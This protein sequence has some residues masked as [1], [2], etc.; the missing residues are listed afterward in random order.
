MDTFGVNYFSSDQPYLIAREKALQW[1]VHE[2]LFQLKPD[3]HNMLQRYILAVFYYQT[4]QK[5]SW[6]NCQ[7]PSSSDR[8]F[9][10]YRFHSR[11]EFAMRWLSSTDECQWAGISCHSAEKTVS[12]IA[13]GKFLMLVA[14]R[15]VSGLHRLHH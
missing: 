9:C 6:P 15:V 14:K 13:L 11:D 4:S 5:Q 3:A 12:V 7:P 1:I 8:I 2:D 10:Y